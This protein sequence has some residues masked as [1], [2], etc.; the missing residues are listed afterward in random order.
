MNRRRTALLGILS[1]LGLC[2]FSCKPLGGW[3]YHFVNETDY[4]IRISLAEQYTIDKTK[5]L[6]RP[7]EK[8]D[9]EILLHSKTSK[10]VYVEEASAHFS[11]TA[12]SAF[13]GN[14]YINAVTDGSTVT[15]RQFELNGGI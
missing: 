13:S 9:S 11:W 4:T 6:D 5:D 1:A 7:A 8:L 10:T 14:L 2:F 3:E 15:I 12:E